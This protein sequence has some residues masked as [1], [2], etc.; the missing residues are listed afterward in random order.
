MNRL[1]LVYLH[2]GLLLSGFNTTGQLIDSFTYTSN[3]DAAKAWRAIAP[4]PAAEAEPHGLSLAM[5]FKSGADR[6]YWDRD[7]SWNLASCHSI[8]LDL[9]C[10][11]P[12]AMR[13]LS[14]YFRS[15]KGWYIW[16]NP[17]ANAGRQKV[18]MAK[19]E[20]KTEGTP[21]GWDKIDKI[22]ISPWKG[23]PVNTRLRLHNLAG[24][25][26]R[27]FVVEAGTSISDSA[28]RAVAR[29]AVDRFARWLSM[30]GIG[31]AVIQE[32]EL[33][34]AS[35]NAT[36]LILPY[37]PKLTSAQIQAI[38]SMT[39]RG[40][41]LMVF[42]SSD[43][44]LAKLMQVKIHPVVN[45]RDIARWRGIKF[46]PELAGVPSA[47]H[48]QSWIIGPAEPASDAT[49]VIACWMNAAGQTSR[50]AAILATPHGYWF[51]HLLLDDDLIAKQR[52]LS[53]M[54][55]HLDPAAWMEMSAHMQQE[56]G[57]MDG[58]RNAPETTTAIR[59]LVADG[60]PDSE[61]VEAHLRRFEQKYKESAERAAKQQYRDAVIKAYE[62][63]DL[64]RKAYGIAQK[65]LSGEFRA[66]WDHDGTG[67]YPGDWDRTARMM[68]AA[69]INTIFVN[70]T[71]AGL[72][73]YPSEFL[74]ESFTFELYG[75][76]LGKSIAAARKHGL[77]VHAWVVCWGLENSRADFTAPLKSSGR[78]QQDFKGRDVMWMN[79]AHPDNVRHHLD[80]I[81]EIL[82]TYDVDGIHLDY[83][84]YPGGDACYSSY[85]RNRFSAETGREI[86]KWPEDAR[87]GGPH[88]EAFVKWR[89]RNITSFVRQVRELMT[90]INPDKKLSAAVWGGY[91]QIIQSIG[92]DWA[93]WTRD[94]MVDFVTPMNYANDLYRFT[95]LL[96]QQIQLPGSKGRIYPGIGVTANES[97]LTGDQVVQQVLAARQ[98]GIKGFALFDLSQT[99]VDDTLPTLRLGITRK[100]PASGR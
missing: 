94:G 49:R 59:A 66:V 23:Q 65:P 44:N 68:A 85:T 97:Q 1:P 27:L 93:A 78:I 74:P 48:Q 62:A 73:H 20:F 12:S 80:I 67:W 87:A 81:R 16:N 98:R 83:V 33:V 25:N 77:A 40:G 21:G 50:D 56:A 22:R 99:L 72:S 30:S 43:S 38:R 39:Q 70:A 5:N 91:P 32:S 61:T 42:Y 100:Q 53:G 89:S 17:L 37:N 24:R 52:L 14:I 11:Q 10:D 82:N 41:K 19:T 6:V 60:H 92:Q 86:A 31:H 58:W 75:D 47:V 26:Y 9:S 35:K 55:A 15:G 45:T 90:G 36:V 29:K 7:G 76:Q 28:E 71:W 3:G 13:S 95:A 18:V 79:P 54:V 69:G 57:R 96:D 4:A 51:T 46:N 88:H 64:L 84:R 63:R 34:H 8:E 2:I